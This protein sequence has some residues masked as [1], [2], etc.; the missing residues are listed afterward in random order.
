MSMFFLSVLAGI[1]SLSL[2]NGMEHCDV[3][4]PLVCKWVGGLPPLPH[5]SAAY[6]ISACHFVRARNIMQAY[7]ALS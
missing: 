1:I 6:E 4:C 2:R 7:R 5:G 3:V